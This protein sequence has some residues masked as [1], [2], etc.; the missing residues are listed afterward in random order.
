VIKSLALLLLFLLLLAVS[1]AGQDPSPVRCVV[2]LYHPRGE[3]WKLIKSVEFLPTMGEEELTN[4]S[5]RLPGSGLLLFASVFPTDESMH[6][7]KGADSLKLGLGVSRK[8]GVNAFDV[9]NN[10]VAEVTLSALDTV[11]VERT[12]YVGRRLTLARL[13]CWDSDLE[14]EKRGR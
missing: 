12:V 2:T 4:K 14:K 6:S 9:A 3:E 10:A 11:R 8:S 7:A 5:V 13:E 1:A